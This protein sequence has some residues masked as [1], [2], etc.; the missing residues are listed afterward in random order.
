MNKHKQHVRGLIALV[1]VAVLAVVGFVVWN[2]LENTP[3][4]AA[5]SGTRDSTVLTFERNGHRYRQRQDLNTILLI[6]HDKNPGEEIADL[7]E[8]RFSSGGQA[9]FLVLLAVD[10]NR[11]VVNML[12]IDRDSMA[13]VN[14]LGVTGRPAGSKVMQICLAHAYGD[15][16]VKNDSNTRQA[17]QDFLGGVRIGHTVSMGMHGIQDINRLIGGVTVTVEEDMSS[18]D[19]AF[20]AG[21]TIRLTDEQAYEFCH[22]RRTVGDGKNVSRMRRQQLYLDAATHIVQRKVAASGGFAREL[23]EG[24]MGI[25]NMMDAGNNP[26]NT[27]WFINQLNKAASYTVNPLVKLDGEHSLNPETG[28]IEC[29]VDPDDIL[30]WVITNLCYEI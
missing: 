23:V 28:F 17:V 11:G 19:P 20:V 12:M 6:G 26:T 10:D 27:G 18:V 1:A 5:A 22:A 30:D 21:A 4:E 16:V 24:V 3:E 14:M 7:R 29:V 25:T 9:D 15:T 8:T 2:H 13:R